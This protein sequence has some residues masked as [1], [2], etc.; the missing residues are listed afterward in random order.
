MDTRR[1]YIVA[2]GDSVIL[3]CEAKG[4]PPPSYTWTPC[5]RKRDCDE[6][7]LVVSRVSHDVDYTCKAANAYTND[8]KSV[9]VCKLH[10]LVQLSQRNPHYPKAFHP[11]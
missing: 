8:S 10:L 6:S 5:D 3:N 7:T 9:S 1:E 2:R 4:N 11:L